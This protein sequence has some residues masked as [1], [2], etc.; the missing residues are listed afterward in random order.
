MNHKVTTQPTVEPITLAEA[1]THLRIIH[2]EE[3]N[4]IMGLISA[5][6]KWCE[7]YQ[8]RAY[9][10]QTITAK[11]D[12]FPLTFVLPMP[13]LVSVTSI[14]YI[15]TAGSTQTLS[16]SYYDVDTYAE[17]GRVTEAYSY[18]WPATRIIDNAVTITYVAG[19]GDPADVPE[20]IKHAIK[21]MV[22]HFY[23]MREPVVENTTITN[24]PM[25]VKSLLSATR[26]FR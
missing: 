22:S 4:Y 2:D 20:H 8:N 12:A 16:S 25:S 10:T 26:N 17:P 9:I 15:D 3:D 11:C 23:E 21:L 5:A 19:Y 6:R 7:Y 13:P 24:V 14:Q 1:K 18:S